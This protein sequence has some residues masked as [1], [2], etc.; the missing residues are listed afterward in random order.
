MSRQEQKVELTGRFAATLPDGQAVVVTEHTE[1]LR[2]QE[3]S[4]IWSPWLAGA[5]RFR[6]GTVALNL[7]EDGDWETAEYAPR[8][9]TRQR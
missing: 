1:Y 9:V 5:R 6:M 4:G 2:V 7:L 3:L 8:R